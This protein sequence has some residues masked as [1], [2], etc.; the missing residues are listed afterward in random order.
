MKHLRYLNKYFWK[1]KFRF[2]LGIMFVIIANVFSLFPPKILGLA[3][4][5]ITDNI[6]WFRLFQG[7]EMR[8][9]YFFL[10][11]SMLLIFSVIIIV[12]ALIR[13]LFMFFMRQTII[14]MSRMIEFDLQNEMYHHYQQLHSGFYKVNNTGDLMSR[15][16]E[17]VARIRM[18]IGPAIMYTINLIALFVLVI[19]TMFA[20]NPYLSFIVLLPLPILSYSI[21]KVSS[22]INTKSEVIQGKLSGLTTMTQEVY[23]G[24]RVLKSYVR[25]A[26]Y[27]KDFD[28]ASVDYR[29]SSLELSKIESFFGPLML[30]LIGLSTILTVFIGGIEV[31][32]GRF[33]PGNIAEFVYYINMLTWPV[34]SLGWV[35]SLVQRAAASQKRINEFLNVQPE[36]VNTMA[37]PL[38]K[39]KAVEFDNVSFTYENTGI[40]A[41][42][43]ISFK[44]ENGQQYAI[45]GRTGSGKSTL[46]E[47]LL[48]SFDATQGEIKINNHSI[49]DLD[50]H[51]LR[52][53]IGYVP[54]DV[55]L[56]SETVE[57]NIKFGNESADLNAVKEAAKLA[58]IHEDILYLKDDYQTLVGERGVTLSG[59]QKQRISI[60][61]ALVKLPEMLILDDCL[62]A[63]DARTEHRILTHFQEAFKNKTVLF[64]THRIFALMDFDQILVLDEG[65][66]EEQGT[67]S[68]LLAK[69]GLYW[70]MYHLQQQESIN[71]EQKFA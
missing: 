50:M 14:V 59:G 67:H 24:I 62:S 52:R 64:I 51:Q 58:E 11:N 6:Q 42:K 71:L 20:V 46:A 41:L 38:E 25:E 61:R 48:R 36:I 13:G 22:L 30:L 10:F 12:M 69:K 68:E 49:L 63:V 26:A 9:K 65:R 33:T 34:A 2:A 17:D 15:V 23:S 5:V 45:I 29:K 39:I 16:T 8:E 44:I 43:N 55:F 53:K 40:S 35:A 57:N 7:F 66:I 56:F 54:Q 21:Y 37:L 31:S 70:E 28:A 18:Y 27:A 32:K 47:L 19:T 1:Y 3:I 4:D 60:A